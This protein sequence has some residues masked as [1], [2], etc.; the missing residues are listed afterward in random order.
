MP[1]GRPALRVARLRR[2]TL[3]NG[4]AIGCAHRLASDL[5]ARLVTENSRENRLKALFDGDQQASQWST[6]Q[7]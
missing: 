4:R 3:A 2:W 5:C 6:Q 1:K 7:H